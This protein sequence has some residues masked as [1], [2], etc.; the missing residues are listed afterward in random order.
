MY[1]KLVHVNIIFFTEVNSKLKILVALWYE[2]SLSLSL[3]SLPLP[4]LSLYYVLECLHKEYARMFTSHD[5][6]FDNLIGVNNLTLIITIIP[7]IKRYRISLDN[8]L[9]VLKI[10]DFWNTFF[11]W[12]QLTCKFLEYWRIFKYY[13]KL[14]D[15]IMID[16]TI[17]KLYFLRKINWDFL[18]Q[19]HILHPWWKETCFG[20]R[21]SPSFE[22]I[23][24]LRKRKY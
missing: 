7:T 4:Y 21:K 12:L 20:G 14:I 5:T 15:R 24:K 16:L 10:P 11:S 23:W 19:K 3:S 8:T 6:A 18:V 13:S 22:F 1:K 2:I 17:F 9:F